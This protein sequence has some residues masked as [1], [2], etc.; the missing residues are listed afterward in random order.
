MLPVSGIFVIFKRL[1]DQDVVIKQHSPDFEVGKQ[2]FLLKLYSRLGNKTL[3]PW[4]LG[5]QSIRCPLVRGEGLGNCCP[6]PSVW[7]N[8]FPEP[9]PLPLDNSLTVSPRSHGI[10]IYCKWEMSDCNQQA[11]L[12]KQLEIT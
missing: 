7:G 3:I 10:S 2:L 4:L 8:N 1:N 6:R 9:L 5:E 12:G 11:K